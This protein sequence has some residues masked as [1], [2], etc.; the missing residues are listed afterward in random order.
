[1]K[2]GSRFLKITQS[3]RIQLSSIRHELEQYTNFFEMYVAE[4]HITAIFC[5]Q[6]TS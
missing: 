5:Y 4:Y 2:V 6:N 1:M 3:L